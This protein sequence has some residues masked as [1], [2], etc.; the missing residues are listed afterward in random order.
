MSQE[1]NGM[2]FQQ[3]RQTMVDGQIR[4]NSITD[5]RVIAALAALPREQFVPAAW[6][7]RAYAEALVTLETEAGAPRA[8][9]AP[10]VL[11]KL[12]Q[13]AVVTSTDVVLDVGCN[14]GYSTAL[15][16]KLAAFVVGL[17]ENGAL[18]ATAV[19][20]LAKVEATNTVIVT[21][22]LANG[23]ESSAPYD[24]IML[25]GAI[26]VEPAGLLAQLKDGGRL[27]AIV[28]AGAAAKATVFV[29]SGDNVSQRTVFDAAAPVLP[30][31]AP[32]VSFVF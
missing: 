1:A 24:V 4:P 16:S 7:S 27:V 2:N 18:A 26:A 31:F 6:Q 15:L 12:A 14:S 11:A 10:M 20:N 32:T 30:G 17:E 21:A 19:A 23:Y 3:A 8:M 25:Q 5:S 22:P 13:A 9:L 28:G 29:K